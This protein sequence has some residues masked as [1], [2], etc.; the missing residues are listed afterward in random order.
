MEGA[1][2]KKL[3]VRFALEKK[4]QNALVQ[5]YLFNYNEEEEEG[6]RD[7]IKSLKDLPS[8]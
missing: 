4:E 8:R 3:P 7:E 1:I 5:A 6:K 2:E